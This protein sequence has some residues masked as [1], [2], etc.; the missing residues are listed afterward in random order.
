M[1]SLI[2]D[3]TVSG[4]CVFGYK[5]AKAIEIF[6]YCILHS[7]RIFKSFSSILKLLDFRGGVYALSI[8]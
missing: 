8:S 5:V 3:Y 2:F 7:E 4:S 1:N 6:K